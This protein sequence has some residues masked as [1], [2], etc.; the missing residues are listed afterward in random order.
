MIAEEMFDVIVVGAGSA[1]CVL[2]ARLSEDP[3]RRVALIEAGE[4][5]LPEEVKV[6]A[7][8]ALLPFGSLAW[9]STTTAQAAASGRLVPLVTGR[10]LGGGSS[11]NSMGWMQAH[12]ED[13]DAWAAA[14]A[15]G[16]DAKTIVPL[17]ARIEDH[18]LGAAVTHGAGG[19]MAVSGPRHLHPLALPF[20]WAGV[21]QGWPLSDDLNGVQKLGISLVYSNVRDGRRHSVVDGYLAPAR[22]RPNLTVLA[23]AQVSRLLFDGDRVVG[24]ETR[25]PDGATTEILA[26]HGVV[27][28][29]GA[30]RT[31]QLLMLSG[32]GPGAHLADHGI[33]VVRDLPAVGSHLQ[34]HPAVPVPFML[35]DPAASYPDPQ[36]DYHLARRGPLS[37]LAQ[38][39][40]L[41]P[42]SRQSWDPPV[43]ELIYGLALLGREAGLPAFE[44]PSGAWVTGLVDPESRGNVRLASADPADEV[45]VDPRYLCEESDRRRMREGVR[46]GFRTLR[47]AA[48]RDLVDAL[49]AEPAEDRALDEFIDASLGTY[50]HPA[51]TARIGSDPTASVVDARLRV[52]GVDGLWVA[53][54]SVMPH[55]VRTLPQASVVA[56]A[57]RAAELIAAD[58]DAVH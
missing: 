12:P 46:M 7:H 33:A 39:I 57:E 16:W 54:A 6:P 58:A 34:D 5:S 24:V 40:A 43:P 21:E 17:F 49:I 38:V 14:G 35:K 10:G 36:G 23:T 52:H 55:I 42:S 30:L 9:P 41:V 48:L 8:G 56:I 51:G 25:T 15:D 18:E 28:T 22:N 2:A 26:R 1:G 31:P 20:V 11:I 29:A 53:D 37:T 27:V 4:E 3:G 50:Y 45:I 32:L 44:G 13:Y 19:P 47:S